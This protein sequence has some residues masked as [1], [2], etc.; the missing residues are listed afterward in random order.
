MTE[1]PGLSLAIGCAFAEAKR[2]NHEY[3]G[4]EHLLLAI[5]QSSRNVGTKFLRTRRIGLQRFRRA[6]IKLVC[7]G[8]RLQELHERPITRRA[9][10]AICYAERLAKLRNEFVDDDHLFFGIVNQRE[11]V[12]V[13]IL[14]TLGIQLSELNNL[15]IQ[16]S[17]NEFA[18]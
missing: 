13:Q 11:S 18:G 1:S 9:Q 6:T 7:A 16:F 2:L 10:N 4:T 8:P 14:L 17:T 3:I 15:E 12:A 5:I